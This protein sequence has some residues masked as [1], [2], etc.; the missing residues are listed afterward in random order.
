MIRISFLKKVFY[1][2]NWKRFDSILNLE[3]IPN[4]H[5]NAQG[6]FGNFILG[7]NNKN[8]FI[9]VIPHDTTHIIFL[10]FT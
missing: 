6:Y 9:M 5:L 1:Q 8:E 10:D 3:N 4:Y 2:I 7:K